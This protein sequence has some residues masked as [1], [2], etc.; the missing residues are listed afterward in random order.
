MGRDKSL[1]WCNH[2][3]RARMQ[4]GAEHSCRQ[5][6]IMRAQMHAECMG[7]HLELAQASILH[8]ELHD[9]AD[10]KGGETQPQPYPPF[11]SIVGGPQASSPSPASP[12][13]LHFETACQYTVICLSS[14]H[15]CHSPP[16]REDSLKGSSESSSTSTSCPNRSTSSLPS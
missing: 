8:F 3:M 10:Y 14:R 13:S 5:L 15:T 1:H 7:R 12:K 16:P 2:K 11:F 9:R 4:A 6:L